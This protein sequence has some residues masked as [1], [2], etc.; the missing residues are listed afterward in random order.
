MSREPKTVLCYGD[1][2][3]FGLKP[4][5]PG[6]LASDRYPRAI[7]WTTL[8]QEQLGVG[9][10][11]I[12]EGL[13]GRTTVFERK[14]APWKNGFPPLKTILIS[15]LPVDI[16][17]VML[18]TNDCIAEVGVPAEEIAA[19][20]EKLLVAAKEIFEEQQ[21][22]QPQVV[23]AAPALVHDNYAASTDEAVDESMYLKARELAG[24]YEPLA[25]KYGCAFVNAAGVEVS[26]LDSEH[27][28][29]EGHRQMAQLMYE[30]IAAPVE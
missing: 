21:G 14:D 26:P 7:R 12:P 11:V 5:T 9:Y 29:E 27:L 18:G 3:T 24:L 10:A 13:S 28:T 15:H 20:M 4:V 6:A 2:N 8:L 25:A 1:S 16:F 22:Y 23:L 19:G 30:A 17:V